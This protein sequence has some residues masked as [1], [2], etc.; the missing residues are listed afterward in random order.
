MLLHQ[1]PVLV[2]PHSFIYWW[3]PVNPCLQNL[4]EVNP[5][6]VTD[7]VVGQVFLLFIL[8]R[9]GADVYA[10]MYV[11]IEFVTGLHAKR[12]ILDRVCFSNLIIRKLYQMSTIKHI[13]RGFNWSGGW[14]LTA[15]S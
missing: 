4:V 6:W 8:Q 5:A 7:V 9:T 15:G 11:C 12:S 1:I 2:F 10:F 14:Y 3:H 13:I